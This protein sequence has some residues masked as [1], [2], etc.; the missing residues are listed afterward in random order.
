MK[1]FEFQRKTAELVA[2]ALQRQRLFALADDVGLGKTLVAGEVARFLAI[3]RRRAGPL[4]VVYLTSNRRLAGQNAPRLEFQLGKD[5]HRSSQD[6]ILIWAATPSM[7]RRKIELLAWSVETSFRLRGPGTLRERVLIWKASGVYRRRVRELMGY[8]PG[9]R[10]AKDWPEFLR[11]A[12]RERKS[13]QSFRRLVRSSLRRLFKGVASEISLGHL[14]QEIAREILRDQRFKPHLIVCDEFQ[15]YRVA[16]FPA[17][18]DTS[19][20][21]LQEMIASKTGPRVLFVSATPLEIR[22]LGQQIDHDAARRFIE[23]LSPMVAK[24]LFG[25]GAGYA[26]FEKKLLDF[27]AAHGT[28]I[29]ADRRNQAEKSL[30]VA[31][32][33][34]EKALNSIMVRTERLQHKANNKPDL[35]DPKSWKGM[36]RALAAML[37]TAY[38]EG[39]KFRTGAVTRLWLSSLEFAIGGTTPLYTYAQSLARRGLRRDL[40]KKIRSV[41]SQHWKVAALRKRVEELNVG[42]KVSGG[43]LPVKL[44]ITPSD[45]ECSSKVLIFATWRAALREAICALHEPKLKNRHQKLGTWVTSIILDGPILLNSKLNSKFSDDFIEKIKSMRRT[46]R[47]GTAEAGLAIYNQWLQESFGL[48][49]QNLE[50]AILSIGRKLKAAKSLGDVFQPTREL[51]LNDAA[52]RAFL[53]P[54]VK[55]QNW[56]YHVPGRCLAAAFART[57][58]PGDRI[59]EK[60]LGGISDALHG[61]LT[62]PIAIAVVRANSKGR[63]DFKTRLAQYCKQHRLYQTLVEYLDW[64]CP[65]D[66]HVDRSNKLKDG[67]KDLV[68]SLSLT[69]ARLRPSLLTHSRRRAIFN[70]WAQP[71]GLKQ[72]EKKRDSSVGSET[73]ADPKRRVAFNSPFFPFVLVAS[74]AGEE[75]L[76]FH[77]Y[78]SHVVHWDVVS[79]AASMVQR[80]GR[81]N[82]YR[83]LALRNIFR[84]RATTDGFMWHEHVKREDRGTQ[85]PI[86]FAHEKA[87]IKREFLVLPFTEEAHRRD[88][89]LRRLHYLGLMLGQVDSRSFEKLDRAMDQVPKTQHRKI[90]RRLPEFWIQLAP[91]VPEPA[92]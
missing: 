1:P 37:A 29:S 22:T 33:T 75:G 3:R 25:A 85:L 82:R 73:T 58:A 74:Q 28:G 20:N 76:D 34:V 60:D 2:D 10:R 49:E 6:R 27:I 21:P 72:S 39:S 66:T 47:K 8:A 43:W 7:R 5:A 26:Q 44:W 56:S 19:N 65:D 48:R 11:L 79:D 90:L 45:K 53:Q 80:E 88:Q 59:D 91:K 31:K 71:F 61:F 24:K 62:R 38:K 9:S 69:P 64:L 77:G 18:A 87:K 81:V 13:P 78:C 42:R 55:R 14:R 50:T 54:L 40:S 4:L 51:K 68:T 92:L 15:R 17:S 35:A 23:R 41:I 52:W 86:S 36:G 84:K 63:E 89:F 32:E 46:T 12:R 83:C 67:I 30:V 70:H 57:L 16:I